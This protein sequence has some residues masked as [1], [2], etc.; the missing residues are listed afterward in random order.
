LD[1]AAC[2]PAGGAGHPLCLTRSGLSQG[3]EHWRPIG[4]CPEARPARD[5]VLTMCGV[6]VGSMHLSNI[7]ELHL[8]STSACGIHMDV[9]AGVP[10][11]E[12]AVH[13]VHG[14]FE[15]TGSAPPRGLW[16]LDSVLRH[17]RVLPSCFDVNM[18][19]RGQ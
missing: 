19:H 10:P 2:V 7:I 13:D 9:S 8:S 1:V 11:R 5:D 15:E 17:E 4:V 14:C 6:T 18:G 3:F 12:T 16:L